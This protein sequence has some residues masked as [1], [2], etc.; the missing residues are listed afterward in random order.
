MLL[1]RSAILTA[2]SLPVFCAEPVRV[3]ADPPAKA[4]F[5][6]ATTGSDDNPGTLEKPFATLARARDAVH[7]LKHDKKRKADVIVLIRGGTYVLSEPVTFGPADSGTKD[8]RIIYAAYR[9]EKPVF[10]GGRVIT[11]WKAGEGKRWVAEVPATKDGSWRFTQLFV[12]GRRQTR[13][14]LPDTDD[15]NKWW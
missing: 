7:R 14:R 5:Y 3:A 6:V 4:D 12:N 13:A 2:L 1:S 8:R 9:E 15:W 10:S 11:G